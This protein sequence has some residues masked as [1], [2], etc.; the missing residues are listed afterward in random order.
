MNKNNYKSTIMITD[1]VGYSKLSGDNQDVALE[2]LK[3]HDKI[4]F[5]SLKKYKGNILK[6]RGDGVISQFDN[7]VKSIYCAVDIQKKLNKRNSL[8]IKE[9]KLYIRIGIHY[10]EFVSEGD[11]IHGDCISIA[12]KL[13]PIAPSGGIVISKELCDI[14][15]NNDS[16]YL[17]EFKEVNLNDKSKDVIYEI[18]TDIFEWYKNKKN[19]KTPEIQGDLLKK[20]HEN[21]NS[22]NYSEAIK[23]A[24]FFKESSS[25]QDLLNVESFLANSFIFLGYFDEAKKILDRI[26]NDYS[27]NSNEF[28]GHV[29]KLHGH[30]NFNKKNW[31]KSHEFYKKSLNLFSKEKSKYINEVYF[32]MSMIDIIKDVKKTS[33]DFSLNDCVY[34]DDFKQLL[35]IQKNIFE[36]NENEKSDIEK[37]IKLIEKFKN[38]RLKAYGFLLISKVFN[39]FNKINDAYKFETKAQEAIKASSHDIS[40]AFLRKNYLEKVFLNKIIIT[41]TSISVDDLF[42][43]E[44]IDKFDEIENFDTYDYCVNCG[45]ENIEENSNCI[46]CDTVLVKEYYEQS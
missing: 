10:G 27:E 1:I 32:Y 15:K 35:I 9:R 8:N 42:D 5:S 24:V 44:S 31:T 19:K 25:C 6:N 38:N 23:S 41:E 2:L 12:S 46:E 40:D 34:M 36:K 22:G 26:K 33:F 17:R 21:F 45:L 20:S 39:Q 16:V 18:Y 30:L 14:V 4:L 11:E 37:K 7:H 28:M 29:Y 43:D 3:E 13:E